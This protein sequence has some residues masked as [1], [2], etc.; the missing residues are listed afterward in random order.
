[1]RGV[2]V[3]IAFMSSDDLSFV[4]IDTVHLIDPSAHVCLAHIAQW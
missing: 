2:G 3:T 1:M 4:Y